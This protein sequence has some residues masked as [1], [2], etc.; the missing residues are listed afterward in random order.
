M[1]HFEWYTPIDEDYH[2]YMICHAKVV[3]SAEEEAEFREKCKDEYIRMTWQAPAEQADP[4]GDGPEWG[5]NNFDSF[6]REQTHHVY[7][8]E[9]HWHREHLIRPDMIITKWR[10]LVNKRMRGIQN[11][12]GWARSEDWSPDGRNYDPKRVW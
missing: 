9:D 11:R 7:Q 8:Y 2:S 3:N 6:G 1:L 10:L 12:H 4:M 5:F